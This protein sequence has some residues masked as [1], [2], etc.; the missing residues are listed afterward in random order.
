[1][2]FFLFIFIAFFIFYPKVSGRERTNSSYYIKKNL[3]PKEK[4]TNAED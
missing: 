2:L 4:S 3:R 1:M